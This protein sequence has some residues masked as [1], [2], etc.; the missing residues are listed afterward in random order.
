MSR[1]TFSQRLG[2]SIRYPLLFLGL[3]WAIMAFQVLFH[4][5]LGHFGIYPRTTWGLI[6]IL[7]A[8]LLHGGWAHLISNSVPFL[9]LSIIVL[10]FYRKIA[11]PAFTLIYLLTGLC[12]WLFGR[13]VFHIGASGVIYGLVAFVFWNG[14]FRRNLKSIA[15]AMIVMFYYGSMFLGILP[16]QDGIS[17]ESHLLGGV[18]GILVSFLFKNQLE[19]DERPE[20]RQLEETSE[21][22]F[23]LNR[24][25]FDKT[26]QERQREKES[27]DPLSG[28]FSNRS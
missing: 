18:V 17:W 15:L 1:L 19:S 20:I 28:W 27:Q 11:L 4:I 25:A 16:G 23:F 14:V 10:F 8:P 5:D 2:T 3:M 21:P 26:R 12:V 9:F 13:P 22:T 7:F 24:D 6:G